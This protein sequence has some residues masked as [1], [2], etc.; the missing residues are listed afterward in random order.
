MDLKLD[1][2]LVDPAR[3][4]A[5]AMIDWDMATRGPADFDLAILI[6]YWVEPGDPAGVL[7]LAAV[8]SL[9]PGWP[10][11]AAV[12]ADYAAAAGRP[13]GDMVW[14]VAL[15][16]LRLAV[17]WMQLYRK[18]QRGELTGDGYRGFESLAD[19]I[20]DMAL[21]RLQQGRI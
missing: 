13:P 4:Q 1:N 21:A 8:P 11:R 9:L 20:A 6:S 10:D 19:A 17:A 12:I 18:W 16:R 7:P 5:T 14:P 3:L 2:L 15:A